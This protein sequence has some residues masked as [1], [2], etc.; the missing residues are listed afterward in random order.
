MLPHEDV[1]AEVSK[2]PE[3]KLA[4]EVAEA[5]KQFANHPQLQGKYIRIVLYLWLFMW[6]VC[7]LQNKIH[8]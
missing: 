3:H 5:A 8:S 1:S 2:I 4:E 6:M 7:L